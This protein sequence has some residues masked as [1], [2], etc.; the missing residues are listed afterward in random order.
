MKANI[1]IL[2]SGVLF[3]LAF[4]FS[5]TTYVDIDN[6]GSSSST[7]GSSSSLDG[8]NSSSYKTVQIGEQIW[9]A[10]NLNYD[11]TGSKCY[12]NL[13]SNCYIY[14]RL[15]DWTTAMA[16]PSICNS[17]SC[18]NQIQS[19][20]R[21][22]CPEG[23]HIPSDGEWTELTG[24]LGVASSAGSKLKTT[25]GW[26][27]HATYGNGTDDYGFSAL[28][29]GFSENENFSDLGGRGNWWCATE[30]STDIAYYRD[31]VNFTG[32]VYRGIYYKDVLHSVR[33]VKN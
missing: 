2:L 32:D 13:E 18:A 31:M 24:F 5:C 11:V 3:A 30:Y 22:I 10:E 4:I 20:H 28:P 17:I 23:W 25:S 6:G 12:D 7:G 19:P 29:G 15:Y 16:L 27:A 1:F 26:D 21:G 33:C 9:M 8:S 14:G